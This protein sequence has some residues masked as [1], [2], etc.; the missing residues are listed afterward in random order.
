MT[1]SF[2][3][4][5]SDLLARGKLRLASD[6]V[7]VRVDSDQ[8]DLRSDSL[9]VA[10]DTAK[11]AI[12]RGLLGTVVAVGPGHRP[13]H[14]TILRAL[15]NGEKPADTRFGP[16][17]ETQVKVGERVVLA[18]QIAGDLWPLQR[19]DTNGDLVIEDYRCVREAE[20]LAVIED[21]AA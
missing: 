18:S 14:P 21:R 15:R 12:N 6:N 10:P 2:W 19:R 8:G 13:E 7:L 16:L 9:I 11:R 17:I 5:V 20:I 3:E 1:G 4:R